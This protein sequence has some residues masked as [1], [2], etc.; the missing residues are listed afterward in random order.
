MSVG[1]DV[2]KRE[3]L[4]TVSGD[5]C[6]AAT[7]QNN[8]KVSQNFKNTY[9]IWSSNSTSGYLSKENKSTNLKRY[10]HPHIYCSIIH[11]S[12]DMEST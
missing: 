8:M 5:I 6:F 3:H 7:K 12:Q 11:N 2:D 9:T 1:E 4:W 10:M